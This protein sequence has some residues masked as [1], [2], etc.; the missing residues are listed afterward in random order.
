MYHVNLPPDVD[1][2]CDTCGG[3]VVQRDDDT[4]E[5]IDRRLELYERETV[6]IID[7]YREQRPARR[8]ST[9]SAKATT[10]SSAS[11]RSSTST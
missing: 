9:A 10:C 3:Q 7:Y 6:P 8:S 5:A 4:E 2:T 11:S 1:W